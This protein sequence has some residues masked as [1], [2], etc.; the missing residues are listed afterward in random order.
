MDNDA[1][2]HVAA[3]VAADLD[4]N[5]DVDNNVAWW[6]GIFRTPVWRALF[7][8]WATFWSRIS[9]HQKYPSH[10]THK[11]INTKIF[12]TEFSPDRGQRRYTDVSYRTTHIIKTA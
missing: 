7:Y 12:H 6:R 11:I 5:D 8:Q 9:A 3:D 2:F 4:D 10:L 1:V